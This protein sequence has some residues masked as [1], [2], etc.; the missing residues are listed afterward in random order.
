MILIV[1]LGN[2]G[3]EYAKTRHNC[4]FTI[5]DALVK[6]LNFDPF[7]LKKNLKAELSEGIFNNVKVIVA[8]PITFMNLSGE[9]V[10]KIAKYYNIQINDIWL[11]HDDLDLP[12]GQ[13]R[14]RKE[15]G[16]GTH[17]GM[18]SVTESLGSEHFPRLKIGIESRGITSPGQQDTTSFVLS[19]F[20]KEEIDIW[21]KTIERTVSAIKLCL[22]D[23]IV[24]AM[25][26]FN[27]N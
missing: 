23:G 19:P 20:P 2:P 10:V 16:P 8:K 3:L 21:L 7:A 15:G 6:D 13:I 12:L 24:S 11:I 26:N 18:K 4:G 5:A 17:N 1:G 27:T 22:K 9:A 25:N 14:I